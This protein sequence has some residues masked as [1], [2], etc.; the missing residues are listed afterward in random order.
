MNEIATMGDTQYWNCNIPKRM[1]HD[2]SCKKCLAL[3]FRTIDSKHHCHIPFAPI[4]CRAQ[5]IARVNT[6][7]CAHRRA[8]QNQQMKMNGRSESLFGILLFF[9][10][11]TGR[12]YLCENGESFV[13]QCC[14]TFA[15]CMFLNHYVTTFPTWSNVSM[16]IM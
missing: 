5:G 9:L 8:P 1:I 7:E 2:A 14:C 12:T 3:F 10:L 16:L 15:C 11:Q 4:A 13:V 6:V